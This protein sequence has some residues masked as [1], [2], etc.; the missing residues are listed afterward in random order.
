MEKNPTINGH[1]GGLFGAK[2]PSPS[3]GSGAQSV[4]WFSRVK[5]TGTS[6]SF[7]GK[8]MVSGEDFPFFVNPLMDGLYTIWLFNIAAT[9]MENPLEMEAYS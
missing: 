6:M 3:N 1:F 2:Q 7:M 5:I 9:A 4:D 8:S